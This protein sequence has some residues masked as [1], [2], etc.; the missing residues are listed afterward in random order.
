MSVAGELDVTWTVWFD[1]V[2]DFLALFFFSLAVYNLANSTHQR[3]L[4][5]RSLP[6]MSNIK[7]SPAKRKS[8]AKEGVYFKKIKVVPKLKLADATLQCDRMD[9]DGFADGEA[10]LR[11]TGVPDH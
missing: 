5:C 2:L 6:C 4:I 3:K 8:D 7:K 1:H 10:T 9:N 11:I